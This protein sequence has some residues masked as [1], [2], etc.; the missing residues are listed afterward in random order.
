VT[1]DF[2][3]QSVLLG[4]GLRL[5]SVDGYLVKRVSQYVLRCNA[6][7]L[8]QPNTEKL[9]CGRCGGSH[10]SRVAASVDPNTGA[11]VLHLKSD[12]KYKQQGTQYAL[13]KPGAQRKGRFQGA[14]VLRED[15]LMMGIWA[16]KTAPKAKEKTSM[17][18]AEVNEK[19]GVNVKK[20][21]HTV[22]VGAGRQNPNAAKGRE[23]RGQKKK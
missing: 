19:T 21:A 14:M 10:L 22:V 23:R 5:L 16:Q 3:M 18:G 4:I 15:Q 8:V 11:Q 2:A 1:T 20:S 13:P 9:F 7:F 12:Y 17:F 6:C